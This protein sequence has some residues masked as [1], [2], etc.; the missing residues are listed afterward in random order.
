MNAQIEIIGLK[1]LLRDVSRAGGNAT[2]LVHA[3]V[4]DSANHVQSQTRAR[5]AHRT[6]ALQRSI[7]PEIFETSAMVRVNEK[8][9]K[10]H[11]YGTGEIVAKKAKALRFT[12]GGET[13]YRKRTRGI[14]ARP[15]FS[16]G[17]D[18]S[19]DYIQRRFTQL[20]EIIV[21]QMAGH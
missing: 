5:A 19:R 8:Y 20:T 16:P 11:E 13:L 12:V 1:E 6:G 4:V 7:M 10:Y 21:K 3:A 18:A 9:G 17:I 15:F 14:K 2:P